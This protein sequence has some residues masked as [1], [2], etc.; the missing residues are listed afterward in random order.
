MDLGELFGRPA[1]RLA[2]PRR[3]GLLLFACGL[4]MNGLNAYELTTNGSYWVMSMAIGPAACLLGAWR[5]IIGQPWDETKDRM[6]R[7][8]SIVDGVALVVGLAISGMVLLK[9]HEG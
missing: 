3:F 6:K 8:V 7:W 5:L 2:H 9:L 4:V 1:V